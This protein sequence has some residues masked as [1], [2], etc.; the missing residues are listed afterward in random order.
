MEQERHHISEYLNHLLIERGLSDNTIAAYENDLTQFYNFLKANNISIFAVTPNAIIDFLTV[1]EAELKSKSSTIARKTAAIRGFYHYLLTED[2]IDEN[3]LDALDVAKS[4]TKL[5]EILTIEEVDKLLSMPDLTTKTGYRDLAMMEV[6]YAT[7]LRVSELLGLDLGDID[8]L[9][10]VRCFGKGGKER[11]VPIGTKALRAV[12]L[13]IQRCR[14]RLVKHRSET[15]LFVNTRGKRMTRQGFWRILKQ[16]GQQ[17]GIKKPLSPHILR[18]SFATHLIAN[19]ADLRSV[20]QMLGHAD[21][22]TTQIYTHLT[23]EHLRTVYQTNHPRAK[24]N[25][26]RKDC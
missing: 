9:G 8:P 26:A 23:R 16:Y 13:Y 17:C 12:E 6:L 10:Y 20:Q 15:A 14:S 7:G 4:E 5:P 11:I 18:H 19:G 1:I 25:S 24:I 3:P 2:L 22:A 21:I